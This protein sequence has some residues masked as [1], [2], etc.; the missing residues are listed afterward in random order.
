MLDFNL[1]FVLVDYTFEHLYF[2]ALTAV[3]LHWTVYD[4]YVIEI[5]SIKEFA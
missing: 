3:G 4:N 2:F 5:V 1:S